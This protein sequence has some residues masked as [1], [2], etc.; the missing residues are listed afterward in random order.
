MLL[1]S[2]FIIRLILFPVPG[3]EI[4]LN[5]FSSWFNTAAQYGP[6]VFYNVVQWCD[7]PPLNIY[8]FW[9]IGS[10]ANSFS[11]FGTPQMA[12][13]IK[14]IP[15]IF[16][17]ATII[18]IFVFLRNRIN[19]KL[20]IIVASLYAFNPAIIINSAV[21]GQ[22]DAIY[23]FLLLLSLTLAL[24]L[25]PKLSMVFLVLSLLTK[26]QSIAIAPLILFVIFKKTD[27]R[28]FV[29][30]LFAGILTM[31]AVIIPF[32]WSNPFSFLSNI[33]FGAYQGYTYTTV[34]AFNLWAL[35][36][37]W[38]RETT[39]LFLIGWILFGTLVV[40]S[41]YVLQKRLTNTGDLLVIFVAFLLVLGF[42]MLPTRIHERYLF[43]ALGI[44]ALAY[45]FLKKIRPIYIILSITFFINQAYVLYH[46]NL[47]IFI[48]KGDPVVLAVSSIN[49]IILMYA[50]TVLWDEFKGKSWIR[51]D[52]IK[53]NSK[54]K[55]EEKQYGN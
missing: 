28:T 36:G 23:T 39:F 53:F 43:P 9:G 55:S 37:L 30:S 38:V 35:G 7:Y 26:P 42:F 8:V 18:V 52:S 11:I 17:I 33:Y 48:S 14:L 3:Y 16:D 22:L 46:L 4:D 51:S 49:L 15:S 21:W 13:L 32:Q 12:Y 6:R 5:T 27:V 1:S 25:K 54:V 19:F 2:A 31:F 41:L 45:P 24:A 50:L 34:N 10:I 47:G 29:V 44:L 20:A 40:F